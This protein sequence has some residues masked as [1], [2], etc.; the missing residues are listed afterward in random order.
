[1]KRGSIELLKCRLNAA[2]WGSPGAINLVELSVRSNR[3]LNMMSVKTFVHFIAIT[4]KGLGTH[5]PVHG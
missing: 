3:G 1:M 5:G 4:K 2:V